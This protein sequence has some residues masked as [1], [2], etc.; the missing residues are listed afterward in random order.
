MFESPLKGTVGE[1]G[2]SCLQG[3]LLRV[4]ANV[5]TPIHDMCDGMTFPEPSKLL[6]GHMLKT[7]NL[8][9]RDGLSS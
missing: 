1:D 3:I 8:G 2:D 4:Y 5:H 9:W 7:F 6:V